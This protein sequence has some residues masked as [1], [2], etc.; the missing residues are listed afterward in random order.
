MNENPYSYLWE[1]GRVEN[2]TLLDE[3]I[4]VLKSVILIFS[5]DMA[6]GSSIT[7][8]DFDE[9]EKKLRQL[10]VYAVSIN[11]GAFYTFLCHSPHLQGLRRR[12]NLVVNISYYQKKNSLLFL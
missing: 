4:T 8:P 12:P 11:L 1:T 2:L 5:Y 6:S 9:S 10:N 3:P 7:F